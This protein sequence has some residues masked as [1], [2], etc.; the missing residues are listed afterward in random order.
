MKFK[1][2]AEIYT[3][4]TSSRVAIPPAGIVGGLGIPSP[5][6]SA[7]AGMMDVLECGSDTAAKSLVVLRCAGEQLVGGAVIKDEEDEY[8][9]EDLG[10]NPAAA[11]TVRLADLRPPLQPLTSC[12]FLRVCRCQLAMGRRA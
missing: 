6:A 1:Q 4:E 7:P 11:I 10:V 3:Q 2:D 9:D 5:A 12:C 8:S